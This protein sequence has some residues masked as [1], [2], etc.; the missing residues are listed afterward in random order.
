MRRL[1]GADIY[2]NLD[3]QNQLVYTSGSSAGGVIQYNS[4]PQIGIGN[5]S[6]DKQEKKEGEAGKE[7]TVESKKESKEGEI[8]V[9]PELAEQLPEKV[10][11]KDFI[12]A[13]KDKNGENLFDNGQSPV[14][15]IKIDSSLKEE[16]AKEVGIQPVTSNEPQVAR[17][18]DR[19]C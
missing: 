5:N 17:R 19:S 8:E 11:A 4:I 6:R 3:K 18:A 9:N 7:K 13:V 10:D 12:N 1:R 2:A 15:D 16:A 14:A